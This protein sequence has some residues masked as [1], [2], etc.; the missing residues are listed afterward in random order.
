GC[1][2]QGGEQLRQELLI[3]EAERQQHGG[4][5]KIVENGSDSQ[6]LK[7]FL[8]QKKERA[9]P[10]SGRMV[11]YLKREKR[12]DSLV[13]SRPVAP[14]A[15]K[16]LYLYGNVGCG[17]TMLMDMFYNATEGVVKHRHRLHFHAAMLDVHARMHKIWQNQRYEKPLQAR[18]SGWIASL[19]FEGTVKEWLAVQERYEQELHLDNILG[20]AADSLLNIGDGSHVEGATILCFDEIQ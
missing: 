20:S 15:P 18:L 11:S 17:K 16:G 6:I 9:E 3:E 2:K 12:L 8:R 13:G 14:P 19:P 4:L 10:G 1:G 7:W 5:W